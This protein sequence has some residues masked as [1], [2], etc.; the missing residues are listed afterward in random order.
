MPGHLSLRRGDTAIFD[1]LKVPSG[2]I[3]L[4]LPMFIV[5]NII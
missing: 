4:S 1:I 2:L 5:I 3:Y